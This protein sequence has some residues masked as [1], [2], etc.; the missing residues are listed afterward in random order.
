MGV[1]GDLSKLAELRSAIRAA[2]SGALRARLLKAAASEALTQVQLEFRE[3]VDPTGQPW[4]PLKYRD[5]MPLRDTGR[6]ANSFSSRPTTTGFVVGTN[7]SYAAYHQ[8]G[9]HGRKRAMQRAQA[10]DKRGRFTS[11]PK[12]V[13]AMRMLNFTA[14]QGGIPARP[15]VPVG[16]LSQRWQLAIERAVKAAFD[17]FMR[18][19]GR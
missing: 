1:R 3:S 19:L 14:G 9:T 5:G 12:R 18:R 11:K 13:V 10:V 17:N 2:A 16:G 7:V 8:Y 4:K 6:L 15:M